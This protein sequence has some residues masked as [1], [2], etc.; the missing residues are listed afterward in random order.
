VLRWRFVA[1]FLAPLSISF[2]NYYA[3]YA[4]RGY[5]GTW[6]YIHNNTFEGN[7]FYVYYG[8]AWNSQ[9]HLSFQ[10]IRIGEQLSGFFFSPVIFQLVY[11]LHA[12]YS[13]EIQTTS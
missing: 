2:S 7:R 11:S 8:E 5:A 3:L 13:A 6:Q 9:A 4:G 12:G 10:G 1:P